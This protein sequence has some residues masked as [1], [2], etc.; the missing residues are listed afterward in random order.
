MIRLPPRFT[1]VRSSAASDVYKGQGE[2]PS[3][4]RKKKREKSR[5]VTLNTMAPPLQPSPSP[6][7][8]LATR[9]TT[10]D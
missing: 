6:R 10:Y 1:R 9:M 7:D 4:K 5:G 3:Q 8:A 2:N